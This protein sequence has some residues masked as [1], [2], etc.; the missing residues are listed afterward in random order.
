MSKAKNLDKELIKSQKNLDT[1]LSESNK[2]LETMLAYGST[3]LGLNNLKKE[4]YAEENIK[5]D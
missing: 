3:N 4:N 1:E 5:A 2:E